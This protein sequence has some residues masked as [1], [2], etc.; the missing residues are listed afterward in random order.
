MD[1]TFG[2]LEL[3]LFGV[4]RLIIDIDFEHK[5]F[6]WVDTKLVLHSL[7]LSADEFLDA[8]ILAGF[9]YCVTFPPLLE[10]QFSFRHACEMVKN[11][12]TGFAAVRQF[13]SQPNVQKLN[14][15]D[16]FLRARCIVRHHPIFS[17]SCVCEP[18]L[19]DSSPSDLHDVIGPRLP[20]DLYFLLSQGIV[21]PY[22][23]D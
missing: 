15:M 20:N 12:K 22:P 4:L 10:Q 16:L 2:G 13:S 7:S 3:L 8:C 9:D 17:A 19:K 18:L 1:T 11:Y 14:Y 23:T 6:D 5:T 21:L